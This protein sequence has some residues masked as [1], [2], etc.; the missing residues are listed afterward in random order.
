MYKVLSFYQIRRFL[1]IHSRFVREKNLF[2]HTSLSLC[3]CRLESHVYVCLKTLFKDTYISV[4][5]V[6]KSIFISLLKFR[7]ES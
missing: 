4:R 1:N 5:C 3:P 7:I 2:S 6:Y